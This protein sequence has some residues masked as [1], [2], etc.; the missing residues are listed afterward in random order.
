MNY[1]LMHPRD[2][3]VLTMERIYR[4]KMTTTSGGN[5]SILDDSG[6]MWITP[7]GVD[8]GSLRAEDIVCVRADGRIAGRHKP[9]SECP[10]HQAVYRARPDLRAI[11]HAHPVALVAFSASGRVPDTRL[12]PQAYRVC[13]DVGYAPYAPPG[14]RQLGEN[15]AAAFAKGFKCVLLEHHGVVTAAPSLQEAFQEFETLEFTAKT[16][17]KASSIGRVRRLSDSQ[18]ETAHL[19]EPRLPEFEPGPRDNQERELRKAVCDFVVRGYHQGLVTSTT[20]SFSARVDERSFLITP[21]AVDRYAIEPSALVLIRDGRRESG[22]TPSR[23]VLN[24]MAIYDRHPQVG[25][26]VSAFPV[27]A[28][29]FSVCD[30]PLTTHTIPESYV[31]LREVRRL[32]YGIQ[33][34]D[35]RALA[36]QVSIERP[37]ALF[38][39]DGVL[40]LGATVLSAFDKLE[41][42]EYTAEALINSHPIGGTKPMSRER[43]A[44]LQ[45]LFPVI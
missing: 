3:I 11:V 18:I 44:E 42:L 8:K 12:F 4:Y 30:V 37:V 35:G 22:R 31:M 21:F 17:I 1:S 38:E 39:N 25:A 41:V 7:G 9:S 24:H 26:V 28:T 34:G 23:A 15:I 2:E 27:N 45:R 40:V 13:G 14:T 29:A 33:Y 36:E 19:M 10:F 6:D 20:G 16:F 5:L 32:P 43:I